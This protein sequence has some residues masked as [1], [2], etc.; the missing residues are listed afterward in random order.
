MSSRW[1]W[2]LSIGLT[3]LAFAA[4]AW[5]YPSLPD[6]LPTHWNIEGQVDGTGPK[7]WVAFG[8]PGLMI[9]MMLLFAAIPWLSP[10]PFKVDA[11][12]PTVSYLMVLVVGLV[13]YIH[14]LTL[15]AGVRGGVD[16]GT[17]LIAGMMFLF[18]ALGNVM[19]KIRRNFYIG[20]RVPWTLASERV[21]TDTHRLAAWLWMGG[22]LLGGILTIAGV[23]PIV[24]FGILIIIS[25]VPIVY[26]F[27]LSKR[28]EKQA[29]VLN[30]QD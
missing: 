14:G 3:V 4:S 11:F 23:T 18:A 28:L 5:L 1:S 22:G 26:S 30:Q 29:L 19:G 15:Y 24:A 12:Q 16:V 27:V 17:A 20:I 25:I 10:A 6:R 13:G 2:G 8:L 7:A 9:A 21:W